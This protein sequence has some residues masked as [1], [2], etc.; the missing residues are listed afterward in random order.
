MKLA[1]TSLQHLVQ[2]AQIGEDEIERARVRADH[3]NVQAAYDA[4]ITMLALSKQY[5]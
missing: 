1:G 5:D 3:P 4:Y 2:S